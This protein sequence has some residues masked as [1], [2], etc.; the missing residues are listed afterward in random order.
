MIFICPK[1]Q[2][3][4]QIHSNNSAADYIISK[5]NDIDTCCGRSIELV[6]ACKTPLTPYHDYLK[7]KEE[8][9]IIDYIID[10]SLRSQPFED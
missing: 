10:Q 8:G 7:S 9:A 5:Y 4:F 2:A 6:C 1:C 3:E